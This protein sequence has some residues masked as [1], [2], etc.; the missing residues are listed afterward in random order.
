MGVT[1]MPPPSHGPEAEGSARY[2]PVPQMPSMQLPDGHATSHE[3]QW[4]GSAAISAQTPLQSTRPG[5]QGTPPSS[6]T[7]LL[8][9]EVV[10]VLVL[11]EVLELVL[12]DVL[13]EVE[14]LV[15]EVDVEVVDVELEVEL[16]APPCP[17]EVELVEPASPLEVLP[18]ELELEVAPP[19]PC[20]PTLP[21]EE[22]LDAPPAPL[23]ALRL[24]TST[25]CSSTIWNPSAHCPPTIDEHPHARLTTESTMSA[26]FICQLLV[27]GSARAARAATEALRCRRRCRGRDV[28][29][30]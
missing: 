25:H 21:P 29:R 4:F 28:G 2:W 20:P 26:R 11:E 24:C 22:L 19:L 1:A 7:P 5:G 18:L 14:L 17:D 10:D 15:V 23:D 6:I 8:E 12:L 16:L 13:V 9:L 27:V 3:P 30:S